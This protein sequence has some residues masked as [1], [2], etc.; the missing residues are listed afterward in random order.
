[1]S[2]MVGVAL[3][4]AYALGTVPT[5]IVVGARHGIDPTTAGSG[6]PGATNM[7]RTG[8]RRAGTLVL[9]VDLLKG[10]VAAAAGL[11]LGGSTLALVVG[12]AAVVGHVFPAQRRFRGGK[13]V[14][15]AAGVGLVALPLLTLA[16]T[17]VFVLIARVTGR[18]SIGS[19]VLCV[20]WPL[21]AALT[22]RP[23]VEV[24]VT[25]LLGALVLSRHRDNL[26]RLVARTEPRL[27]S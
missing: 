2:A 11:V 25:A 14:A 4:L 18:A 6:N 17:V 21:G 3:V 19:M 22:G 8:G 27:G 26:R 9:A 20:L 13:G 10:A 16:L 23:A 15:T 5:A 24:A 1:M 12:A 7:Y